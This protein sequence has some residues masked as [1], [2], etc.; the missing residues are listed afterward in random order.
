MKDFYRKHAA[1]V[2]IDGQYG[3][4]GKGLLAGYL[5]MKSSLPQGHIMHTTNAAPNAGHT[6]VWRE[7]DAAYPLPE[8]AK[9]AAPSI[10]KKLVT[11]HLPTAG[12]IRNELCYINA[13]A[14]VDIGLLK[15]ERQHAWDVMGVKPHIMIHPQAVILEPQDADDEKQLDSSAAKISSTQKGVGSAIARKVRRQAHGMRDWKVFDPNAD[16]KVQALQLNDHLKHGQAIGIEVP[17]G[18]SLGLNHGGFYPYCTSREVSVAQALS[19][20]G[21]HPRWLGLTAL[22]MRT[23]P[24]RVGSLPGQSS[25]GCYYDQREIQWEDIGQPAELTTVT[26]RPR[27]LFTWS[28]QQYRDALVKTMPAVVFLNFCNYFQNIKAFYDHVKMMIE[29]HD[30]VGIKPQLLYGVGPMISDVCDSEAI[31]LGRLNDMFAARQARKDN[32]ATV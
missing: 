20:A 11:Y 23:F 15:R 5:A 25:G 18:L 32:H 29:D 4:T 24:I 31:V 8:D 22:C 7:T 13:G 19:D 26:Q 16:F 1:S 30:L 17:Q 12:V 6:T 2:I 9:F 10:V 21:I 28:R 3:S 27:R 14:V